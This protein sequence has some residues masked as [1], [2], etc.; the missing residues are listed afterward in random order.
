MFKFGN[1]AS[2]M[3]GLQKLPEAI[4]EMNDQLRQETF[5]VEAGDRAVVAHFNGLGEMQRIEF[6]AADHE[7]S[8]LQQWIC[9][10]TNRGHAQAKQMFA[11]SMQ[12]LT[13]ELNIGG[14]PG[15]DGAMASLT[16]G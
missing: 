4:A 10:A 5:T 3:S 16:G 15:M 11:E 12:R 6:A 14:L 9:E 13:E 8:V 1:I 2:M 7:D